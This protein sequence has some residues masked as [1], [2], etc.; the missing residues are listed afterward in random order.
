M[1]SND[2]FDRMIDETMKAMESQ[3]ANDPEKAKFFR[4]M[5]RQQFMAYADKGNADVAGLEHQETIIN[6]EKLKRTVITDNPECLPLSENREKLNFKHEYSEIEYERISYGLKAA[7]MDEKWIIILDGDTLRMWR[8]WHPH[9]C[10]F[11]IRFKKIGKTYSIEEVFVDKNFISE[12]V[13]DKD[14]ASQLLHYIIER[15]LL[16]HRAKFPYP[17]MINDIIQRAAFRHGLVGSSLAN[18]EQ[19]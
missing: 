9:L 14:Y 2:E 10:I 7:S 1:G 5:M 17:A 13:I 8:S 11:E 16:G 19:Y 12:G 6:P 4:E 3:F 18:D 15:M